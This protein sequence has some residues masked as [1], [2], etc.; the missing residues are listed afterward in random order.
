MVHLLQQ[1]RY[2]LDADGKAQR[3]P[4]SPPQIGQLLLIDRDIDLYTPLCTELTY[5]G[6]IHQVAV[7]VAQRGRRRVAAGGR[8]ERS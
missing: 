1:M 4:D 3:L 2:V 8:P 6:L 5:E 7:K